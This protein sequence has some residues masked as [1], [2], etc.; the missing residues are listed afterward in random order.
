MAGEGV[1]LEIATSLAV[2]GDLPAALEAISASFSSLEGKSQALTAA[3]REITGSIG[4]ISE[5]FEKAAGSV[6][7][8]SKSMTDLVEVA[9]VVGS[10]ITGALDAS[11]VEISTGGVAKLSDAISSL[12]VPM[13]TLKSNSAAISSLM[14]EAAEKMTASSDAIKA[15]SAAAAA[16]LAAGGGAGGGGS[17]PPGGPR[18]RKPEEPDHW[19]DKSNQYHGG[20]NIGL[21][22]MLGGVAIFDSFKEAMT[23]QQSLIKI[24]GA[25]G[26]GDQIKDG[27]LPPVL[28]KR[29]RQ[30]LIEP[31]R[32][33][34]YVNE[35]DTAN[36]MAL[37]IRRFSP[38]R[39]GET[40]EEQL[41]GGR[42]MGTLGLRSA[43]L[44]AQSTGGSVKEAIDSFATISEQFGAFTLDK[45]KPLYDMAY[46]MSEVMDRPIS[47]VAGMVTKG[48]TPALSLGMK[49]EDIMR[50]MAYFANRLSPA[51]G[52]VAFENFANA[53]LKAGKEGKEGVTNRLSPDL[54]REIASGKTISEQSQ[55]RL[56]EHFQRGFAGS[57]SPLAR[58]G[59]VDAKGLPTK[60]ARDDAGNFSID[61]A[62][63]HIH[64]LY[65]AA[66]NQDARTVISQEVEQATG[67]RGQRGAELSAD[68]DYLAVRAG[69]EEHYKEQM[70][71][72]QA[73]KAYFESPLGQMR[74]FVSLLEDI[75]N[76]LATKV[77]PELSK[78]LEI[79]NSFLQHTSDALHSDNP[80]ISF[81]SWAAINIGGFG[82]IAVTALAVLGGA[83]NTLAKIFRFGAAVG[84]MLGFG[85]VPDQES[86]I[87]KSTLSK[88]AIPEPEIAPK[89]APVEPPKVTPE[90]P[91]TSPETAI[92]KVGPEVEGESMF[93]RMA[94]AG[95]EGGFKGLI[96]GAI[97]SIVGEVVLSEIVEPGIDAL[98][99]GKG[100]P[101]IKKYV[102]EEN[103][104]NSLLNKL[105]PFGDST[106]TVNKRHQERLDA[107]Q[108]ELKEHPWD[109][110]TGQIKGSSTPAVP[111]N[112]EHQTTPQ[113]PSGLDQAAQAL[114]R[115][116][117]A[118]LD[119]AH[120][121]N[122]ENKAAP[123]INGTGSIPPV[124]NRP[125]A[126][127]RSHP[128]QMP[129]PSGP[130][131]SIPSPLSENSGIS[132]LPQ[133]AMNDINSTKTD[134]NTGFLSAL[135][136]AETSQEVDDWA[137]EYS[138]KIKPFNTNAGPRRFG[139]AI[140]ETPKEYSDKIKPF[141]TN[142]GPRR[143]G[144][145]IPEIP[146][147][148]TRGGTQTA[149]QN[150][151]GTWFTQTKP[152]NFYDTMQA[153]PPPPAPDQAVDSAIDKTI[154][155]GPDQS[156]IDTMLKW[157]PE[158]L[159]KHHGDFAG[160]MR[161]P[162]VPGMDKAT[163]DLK[164]QQL[165]GF[166]QLS[167]DPTIRQE[168]E[169]VWK[170]GNFSGIN[171]PPRYTGPIGHHH[172]PLGEGVPIQAHGFHHYPD[173]G[174]TPLARSPGSL[175]SG[176]GSVPTSSSPQDILSGKPPSDW[177]MADMKK[178]VGM[179]MSPQ[180][181]AG[182]I[183]NITVESKGNNKAVGDSGSA[184]GL[185]Q[186]H[187]DRQALFEQLYHK[188]IKEATHDE[189][190]K[191]YYDELN[192]RHQMPHGATPGY[193]SYSIM[194]DYEA[195]KDRMLGGPNDMQRSGI[196]KSTYDAF[197][198]IP[199]D[200]SVP[201]VME[202]G[203][204][205]SKVPGPNEFTDTK[206]DAFGRYGYAYPDN[207]N[208]IHSTHHVNV[209]LD[210]DTLGSTMVESM[211]RGTNTANR[212]I[213]GFDGLM[214][215]SQPGP[216]IARG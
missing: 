116:A 190:L 19:Y 10:G 31:A 149:I 151:D 112:V 47:E 16:A 41:Q 203:E 67:I 110:T 124:E 81:A 192:L 208:T 103:A 85:S 138:D 174:G 204:I 191:F 176:H 12:N 206:S 51:T 158:K 22:E 70:S 84:K 62:L 88:S 139:S 169:A 37:T 186:W 153:I 98:F 182:A 189:Q 34:G 38:P 211:V 52:G 75:G 214:S 20:L 43:E 144:S 13:D 170:H 63:K 90:P 119:A 123:S 207:S 94:K 11:F 80:V 55:Q 136:P 210:G 95:A 128:S 104:D 160:M 78:F 159:M 120:A 131:L 196:A 130:D 165:L 86:V 50:D 125:Q 162:G 150:R 188:N 121:L 65:M 40:A 4:S 99:G 42:E 79:S 108:R 181:A 202:A 161:I 72:D 133:L 77:L 73:Q 66:P 1:V 113:V 198:A 122:P 48:A 105:N 201:S 180:D 171:Q 200:Q 25:L 157:D 156:N 213:S 27:Q 102:A 115:A 177:Q 135:P 101:R 29:L 6:G 154:G 92:P 107:L 127:S 147:D 21:G 28:E 194:H 5:G 199:K 152:N 32:L 178:L 93:S 26:L 195:P 2:T 89:T 106:D 185:G 33:G 91:K 71:M 8:I 163:T 54:H 45:A 148:H 100:D 49:P 87:P 187:P 146:I 3:I 46:R 56:I 57:E 117:A 132:G 118:L 97:A 59:L 173:S 209:D 61:A 193:S 69:F 126:P 134:A 129:I 183:G 96:V 172:L 111:T 145:E 212:G 35:A 82:V 184:F 197:M 76:T 155:S 17:S 58:L 7:I 15:S 141:N 167:N 60:E 164:M 114:M 168:Q 68:P 179:G 83:F 166:S 216:I 24:A 30:I 140:P 23:E 39:P 74:Q 205:P 143:F 109:P 53:F 9:R 18:N 142:A 175:M 215:P 36:L 44:A 137:K 64:D 14:T